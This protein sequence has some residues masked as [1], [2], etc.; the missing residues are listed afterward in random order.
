MAQANRFFGFMKNLMVV[1]FGLH[2]QERGLKGASH[3]LFEQ[4]GAT[5]LV[6]KPHRTLSLKMQ[7]VELNSTSC[8]VVERNVKMR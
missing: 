3:T 6:T 8:Q 2:W 4:Y 5:R 1:I 7:N